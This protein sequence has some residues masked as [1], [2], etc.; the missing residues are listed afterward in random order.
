LSRTPDPLTSLKSQTLLEAGKDRYL[1][2]AYHVSFWPE[3]SFKGGLF[4]CVCTYWFEYRQ[5]FHSHIRCHSLCLLCYRWTY[6]PGCGEAKTPASPLSTAQ[7][8]IE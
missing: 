4:L 3:L 8:S 5:L 7:P 1:A 2:Q 6:T